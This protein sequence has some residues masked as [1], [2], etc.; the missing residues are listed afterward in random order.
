MERVT[1]RG[2]AEETKV[3]D[4]LLLDDLGL[5]VDGRDVWEQKS[6]RVA[7]TA[8]THADSGDHVRFLTILGLCG[9]GSWVYSGRRHGRAHVCGRSARETSYIR[10]RK[11][12]IRGRFLWKWPWTVPDTEPTWI[13][14]CLVAENRADARPSD[15]VLPHP[16]SPTM[17]QPGT[18]RK[19]YTGLKKALAI[20]LDVGTTFS[21]VSYALLEPGE[22]PKIYEVTRSVLHVPPPP[23][24]RFT[25][26]DAP[27]SIAPFPP[28]LKHAD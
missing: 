9:G 21:G 28:R 11:Q 23:H 26:S 7:V 5:D 25:L 19:P 18:A 22:I 16:L 12:K 14:I 24:F 4:A 10:R 1:H 17:K 2:E 8:S 13:W 3:G 27:A 6:F 20:A 15:P